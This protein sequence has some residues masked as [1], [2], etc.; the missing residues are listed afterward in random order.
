MYE[1]SL[2]RL[3]SDHAAG[4]SLLDLYDYSAGQH[5]VVVEIIIGVS[6]IDAFAGE[7]HA[8]QH[9]YHTTGLQNIAMLHRLRI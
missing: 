5:S 1:L 6:R 4:P 9:F 2:Q 8:R 7:L 3:H